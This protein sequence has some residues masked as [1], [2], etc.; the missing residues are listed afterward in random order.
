[1]R[2]MR[3]N[4]RIGV[5]LNVV[6]EVIRQPLF[7]T[8]LKNIL[9]SDERIFAKKNGRGVRNVLIFPSHHSMLVQIDP[10]RAIWIIIM[11]K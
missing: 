6:L 7:G 5:I 9:L 10:S 4:D 11:C 2:E 8:I 1:M 3:I